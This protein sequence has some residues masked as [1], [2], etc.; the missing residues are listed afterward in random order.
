VLEQALKLLEGSDLET[1][2]NII[3]AG[4][5]PVEWLEKEVQA[6][7]AI[8]PEVLKIAFSGYKPAELTAIVDAIHK[9]YKEKVLEREKFDR[10]E[11]LKK[12]HTMRAK[13]EGELKEAK[14]LQH[15]VMEEAGGAKD[16][17]A[18]Q[19]QAFI[20]LQLSM[21]ERELLQTQMALRRDRAE[22]AV[23][24]RVQDD[25]ARGGVSD[26]DV[27]AELAADPDVRAAQTQVNRTRDR[28]EKA[29]SASKPGDTDPGLQALRRQMA[30]DQAALAE[31]KK[32]LTTDAVERIRD[33]RRKAA[34]EAINRLDV[35]TA[36]DEEI[37][38][39]LQ[40]E[41]TKLRDK[42]QQQMQGIVKLETAREDTTQLEETTRKI[43][44]EE[45]ALKIE[46]E[47]PE[48][49]S[50]LEED[51]VERTPDVRRLALATAGTFVGTFAIVLLAFALPR[52]CVWPT[53]TSP[54][55]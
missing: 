31:V 55:E 41:V 42:L 47:A 3:R 14:N 38:H 12:L 26:A 25:P 35:R 40:A 48:R 27:Q 8:A 1:I 11:R 17:A 30:D 9:A 22:L 32:R 20:Q 39:S 15:K 34:A 52:F 28:I 16:A 13:Y 29:A 6:D 50:V 5:N 46:L 7:F 49:T 54:D 45:E 18:M 36:V 53:D 4:G 51:V 10:G 33:Q 19:G 37:E 2:Q 44:A 43:A 23:L 24:R 21:N